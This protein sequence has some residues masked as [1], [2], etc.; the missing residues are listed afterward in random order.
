MLGAGGCGGD[1]AAP[2]GVAPRS[3]SIAGV[4]LAVPDRW[5]ARTA[6]LPQGGRT[7][8]AWLQA[9]NFPAQTRIR[10]R[11]PLKVMGPND[12]VL[13]ISEGNPTAGNALR[14]AGQQIELTPRDARSYAQT[15]RGQEDLQIARVIGTRSFTIDADFGSPTG[16]R[17]LL[18]TV[19]R[20]VALL[21]VGVQPR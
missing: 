7:G 4:R 17:R 18:P 13:T 11:D 6:I 21:Q 14:L 1:R 3:V 12:V 19:N 20:I 5:F 10:G 16:A 2:S 8:F 15:P 9:S